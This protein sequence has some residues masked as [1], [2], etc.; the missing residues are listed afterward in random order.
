MFNPCEPCCRPKGLLLN[1]GSTLPATALFP[2]GSLDVYQLGAVPPAGLDLARY[3]AVYLVLSVN[4]ATA[5]PTADLVAWL[6]LGGRRLFVSAGEFENYAPNTA[7]ARANALCAAAGVSL[8]LA[9]GAY[10]CGD[11][12]AAP[13][14]PPIYRGCQP[15]T[16]GGAHYLAAG[17]TTWAQAFDTFYQVFATPVTGGTALATF[18]SAAT[19]TAAAPGVVLA[20]E[21][22]PGTTSEV[23]LAGSSHS[24]YATDP[25][26]VPVGCGADKF[27]FLYRLL[28]L[29][30]P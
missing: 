26:N 13:G 20:A 12:L 29:P 22:V 6:G 27:P 24:L 4:A 19:S 8:R 5:V 18:G 17:M 9:T 23:V 16:F 2:A 1:Q 10:L 21:A 30:V 7:P 28:E 25:F 15:G 14:P 11:D 3:R